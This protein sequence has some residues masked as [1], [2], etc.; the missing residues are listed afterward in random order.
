M[1]RQ[2]LNKKPWITSGIIKSMSKRDFYLHKS[3]SKSDEFQVFY[4]EIFKCYRNKI[5]ALIVDK[6]KSTTLLD[7][8]VNIRT[9]STKY[10]KKYFA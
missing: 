7:I 8:F 1:T 5:V 6:E 9:T 4:Y 10:G 3:C 2:Q